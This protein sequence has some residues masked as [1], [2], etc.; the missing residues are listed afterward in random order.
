MLLEWEGGVFD[1]EDGVGVQHFGKSAE[2]GDG[3]FLDGDLQGP[4]DVHCSLVL[5]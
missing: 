5:G 2:E 1:G 3:G 4:A